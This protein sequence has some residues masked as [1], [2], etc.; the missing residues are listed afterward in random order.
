[1]SRRRRRK[2]A[3]VQSSFGDD[4]QAGILD[5][6]A[7][8]V[9]VLTL[10]GALSAII[11]GQSSLR[12]RTP[13]TRNSDQPFMLL[14]VGAAGI[15]NLEPARSLLLAAQQARYDASLACLTNPD[16]SIAACRQQADRYRKQTDIGSATLTTTALNLSLQR[17]QRPDLPLERLQQTDELATMIH[18]ARE[19]GKSLFV[20]LE[21]GGFE[22]YRLIRKRALQAGVNVGWEPWDM[23]KPVIFGKGRQMS[24]Q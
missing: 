11:A 14:Q 6:L 7:N 22:T 5:V 10:V 4:D 24:T 19:Q 12:L 13:M 17:H 8:L 1:V 23:G 9:G 3:G 2:R 15:W 21:P 18:Q 16:R 20:L